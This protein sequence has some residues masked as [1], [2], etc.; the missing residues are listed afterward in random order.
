MS[1]SQSMALQC[2]IDAKGKAV[3]FVLGT[4]ILA[5]GAGLAGYWVWR[6]GM[7]TGI[8]AL[9]LLSAGAFMIFE[10]RAGWCALRAMGWKTPV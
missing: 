6:G 3:R 5:G 9:A 1:I 7:M 4:A 2:N 8:T 10:A